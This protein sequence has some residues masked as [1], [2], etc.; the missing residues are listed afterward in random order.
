[1]SRN[2]D[3]ILN[4][5]LERIAGGEDMQSCLKRYPEHAEELTPLLRAAQTT[6]HIAASTSVRLEAKARGLDHLVRAIS[7]R[8]IP[9]RR[10]F[11]F[12]VFQIPLAARPLVIGFVAVLIVSIAAGGT[13]V[14]AS[15]NSVPGDPLYWVKTTKENISLR[16]VPRSGMEKAEYHAK[17]ASRRG[18]EIRVLMLRGKI[19][20]AERLMIRINDHLKESAAY[21]GIPVVM[22]DPLE[23]PRRS[24][25][26]KRRSPMLRIRAILE[27]D[28]NIMRIRL[29][30]VMSNVPIEQRHR[31]EQIIRRSDLGYRLMIQAFGGNN[32]PELRPF[33]RVQPPGFSP[34]R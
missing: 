33:W 21:A 26:P 28:G 4:E 34:P 17:L 19:T 14:V 11:G 20:D 29:T 22:G 18:K 16:F 24:L 15:S 13:T 9:K 30:D 31:A 5:C 23:A 32:S 2:F 7:D 12:E 25:N 1:M 3:D 10:R 8:G 6:M 27:R